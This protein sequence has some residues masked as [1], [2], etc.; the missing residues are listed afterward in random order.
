MLA[1]VEAER[2]RGDEGVGDAVGKGGADER[3][4]AALGDDVGI[5]KSIGRAFLD[6]DDV[7]ASAGTNGAVAFETEN[8]SRHTAHCATYD[9]DTEHVEHKWQRELYHGC[10]R[11][12]GEGVACFFAEKVGRMVGGDDV[13]DA[14]EN[15]ATQCIAVGCGFNG[16][17][18]LYT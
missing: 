1:V 16:W 17:V 13:D 4:P 11:N 12:G 10:T 6:D 9:V 5:A 2:A 14:V 3:S 8:M 15:A 18:N 7:G